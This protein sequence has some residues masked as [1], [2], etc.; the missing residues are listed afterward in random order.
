MKTYRVPAFT[1]LLYACM[2]MYIY[3]LHT[4]I[5]VYDLH[6]HSS[7]CGWLY[8]HFKNTGIWRYNKLCATPDF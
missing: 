3:A 4:Y 5:H 1:S 6:T 8:C 2:Y 7:Y